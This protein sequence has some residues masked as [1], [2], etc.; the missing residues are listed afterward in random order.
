[1]GVTLV[2]NPQN[3]RSI[4]PNTWSALLMLSTEKERPRGKLE[5]AAVLPAGL[6]HGRSVDNRPHFRQRS[7]SA[8]CAPEGGGGTGIFSILVGIWL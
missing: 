8:H 6:S 4:P 7:T 3:S 5:H 1:M 2:T